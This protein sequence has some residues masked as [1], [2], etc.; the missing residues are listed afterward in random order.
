M[1]DDFVTLEEAAQYECISYSTMQK[2]LKR[3]PDKFQ[4]KTQERE[5]GGLPKVFI[6]VSSLSPKARRAYR[7]DR[8][9]DQEPAPTRT[10][11][12]KDPP[13]YVE[14]DLNSYIESNKRK[15]YEA[16]ELANRLQ[17]FI[18]Y[19]DY[20]KTEYSKEFAQSLGISQ[21]TLY[22]YVG[23]IIEAQAWARKMEQEDGQSR[24]YFR[25][26]SL[27]RKP[28]V[29]DNFPSLTAEQKAYIGAVWFNRNFC[30]NLGT[31][32]MLYTALQEEAKRQGW[33]CPSDR[34]VGRYISYLMEQRGARSAQYLAANGTRDWKNKMM[35]KGKRDTTPLRVMEYVV[36]DEHTFDIWVQYTAPNGKVRAVRPKLTAWEDMRSRAIIGDVISIDANSQTLKESLVKMIYSDIGG[37][38][39]ALH[40]DNGKD[41]TA[42]TMTGQSRSERS[43]DFRF[44]AETVGF[45]QSIGIQEVGRSLPYQ[46]WDKP[47][48]RFF[49]RVCSQFSKWFYSYVGTLTGS[50][51]YAK[52]EKDVEKMLER[53]ELYTLE[54]FY[55]LW[56][57]WK[58]NYMR[59]AHQGLKGDKWHT[60][61]EVFEN[62]ERYEKA[63]PPREYA[64]LLLM[65]SAT[66]R[67]TN[68]GITR[69][70]TLYANYELAYYIG[71]TVGIKWDIDDI[72]KLY[73]F[74]KQ[75]KKICE[76]ESAELLQFYGHV[77]QDALEKHLRNQKRQE[78]ETKEFLERMQRGYAELSDDGRKTATV[79]GIDLT[80][81]PDRKDKIIALP[82]DKEYRQER[83][84]KKA[85]AEN[86][87]LLEKGNEAL[88]RLRAM[89]E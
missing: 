42:K 75:G 59:S 16:V 37:V 76:A 26:L 41:Y 52:R 84:A 77:S 83:K 2:R 62:A 12:D 3:L 36:G 66:A 54:E 48:E 14:Q 27:C 18:D 9:L 20:K 31:R 5:N 15:F 74:D 11:G 87:F 58:E 10:E 19:D 82:A 38:P 61:L 22:R 50:K 21:R 55:K 25:V 79:G 49:G 57:Q 53:G 6:S 34:T 60:P 56:E 28:R 1:L 88:E 35:L 68:Q 39:K 7:A 71:Q 73:V 33:E 81:K 32:E 46:P 40:I 80:L 69:F 17:E 89:N 29:K 8:A 44:D 64:A 47:I 72:T 23:N 65:K 51:T 24:D 78:K 85:N 13:W 70:G 63:A 4:I 67:V 30:A 86:E 45:Y 43:I